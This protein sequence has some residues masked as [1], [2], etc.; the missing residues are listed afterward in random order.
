M[1]VFAILVVIVTQIAYKQRIQIERT[2]QT[3]FLSQAQT[4]AESAEAIAIVGLALDAQNTETDH[5]YELWN[6]SEG[7]FPIDDGGLIQLQLDDLQGRFNVN[8][9]SPNSGYRE[10]ALKA[11]KKLLLA[12]N[13][14][15]E[16]ADELFQWLDPDSGIDFNYSDETPS[17]SPSFRELSDTSELVLLKSVELADY[18][19]I[20]PYISALPA[21]SHLNL[22]T[23][24][25]EVIG[26]IAGYI[27]QK[28]AD[29]AVSDRGET[30]FTAVT[31]FLNQEVFKENE[32]AGI[33]LAELTV[34]SE[35]FELYTAVT[36]NQQTLTQRAILHRDSSGKTTLTLRDRSA[37]EPNPIPGD[38]AK[39]LTEEEDDANAAIDN[40]MEQ[41]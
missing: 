40:E 3:L 37:K 17:Y 12:I 39:G 23:A 32:D 8:W 15:D 2:H 4:Y 6:T 29:K 5:L 1:F 11:F 33:Y 16:I 10:G 38:P 21:D 26:S 13:S 14:K 41:K 36:L 25:A 34:N 20:K 30:G 24:P 18:E 9:L 28:M 31:D 19:R 7:M 22:N 27:D 35:W